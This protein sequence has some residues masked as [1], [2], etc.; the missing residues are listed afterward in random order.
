M[1]RS[2]G[3]GGVYPQQAFCM[4]VYTHTLLANIENNQIAW[5]AL[6]QEG[7]LRKMLITGRIDVL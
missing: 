1:G 5:C 3:I 6:Y 2:S 4:S 7:A